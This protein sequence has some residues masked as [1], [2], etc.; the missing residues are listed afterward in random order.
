MPA[1]I[2]WDDV[3]GA[4]RTVGHLDSTWYDLGSAAG[5]QDVGVRRIRIEP[6]AWST[7]AHVEHGEEEIFYVMGGSGLSWQDEGPGQPAT[8]EVGQGDCIV[9]VATQQLHT[10]Y[11]GSDGLES[12]RSGSGCRGGRVA[13]ARRRRLGR[14]HLG[15][16]R[17]GA[18]AV[19]AGGGR[20]APELPAEPSPRP[21]T[22]VNAPDVPAT[23][24]DGATVAR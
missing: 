18:L 23:T 16:R 19:G 10:L 15:E 3:E 22:I 1:A 5:S 4:R 6:G 8:Y 7:P 17:R 2:H 24:R 13:S 9:H 11:A 21:A 20:R 14:R 12:W